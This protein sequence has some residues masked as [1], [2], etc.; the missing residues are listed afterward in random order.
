MRNLI[1]IFLMLPLSSCIRMGD[2]AFMIEGELIGLPNEEKCLLSL[3]LESEEK[4][5]PW[6]TADIRGIF[7]NGFTVSPYSESYEIRVSCNG[8]L[9]VSK[10]V[11][12]PRDTGVGGTVDLGKLNVQW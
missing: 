6:R 11:N 9:V 10:V 8:N 7:S 1:V 4:A 12:Y 3:S 2:G 5:L